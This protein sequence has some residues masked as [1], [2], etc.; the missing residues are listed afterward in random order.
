MVQEKLCAQIRCYPASDKPFSKVAV[1]GGAYGEGYELAIKAGADAY[2][3]G[4]IAHHEI[5]D[6]CTRGLTIL[7][8]GHFATEWPGVQTLYQRF[9][10]D[11]ASAGWH[12]Q[13]HLHTKAPYAGAHLAL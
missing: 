8:A 6:A 12:I 2:V 1:A 13:A 7:D 3:V 11:F 5:L 9:L 4:E 10:A